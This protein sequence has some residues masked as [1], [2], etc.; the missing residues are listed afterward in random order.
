MVR[1]KGQECH[2]LGAKFASKN[3]LMSYT[4]RLHELGL[5]FLNWKN[6]GNFSHLLDWDILRILSHNI[7]TRDNKL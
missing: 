3:L 5:Y 1:G 7:Q 6:R 2:I 4:N